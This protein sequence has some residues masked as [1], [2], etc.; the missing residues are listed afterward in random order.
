MRRFVFAIGLIGGLAVCAS[1]RA[2]IG[3]PD[4]LT[5]PFAGA[6]GALGARAG[7]PAWAALVLSPA[8]ARRYRELFAVQEA[9]DWA[10]A[11]ALIAALD[12][13]LLM[14][15]A[16]FQRYMHPTAYRSRFDELAAWLEAYADHPGAK[17]IYRLALRRRPAGAPAPA[18]PEG[19][20]AL[21]GYG[22]VLVVPPS[23]FPS[24]A[25]EEEAG[26]LAREAA[27]SARRD[28]TAAVARGNLGRAESILDEPRARRWLSEAERDSLAARI[29]RMHFAAGNDE[30]AARLAQAAAANLGAAA[31]EAQWTAGLAAWRLGDRETAARHF[32]VL[33]EAG[34]GAGEL[35]AGGAYWAARAYDALGGASRAERM[36]R[37]GARHSYSAYGLLALRQLGG[38]PEFSW[39]PPRADA[40][41]ARLMARGGAARRAAALAEAGR[42]DLAEAELRGLYPDLAREDAA[43]LLLLAERLNLPG[44]ALRVGSQIAAVGGDRFDRALYPLPSWRPEGGFRFDRALVFALIRRESVFET[45][46]ESRAGARGLMQLMPETAAYVIGDSDARAIRAELYAPARNLDLGQ[47]YMAYLARRSHISSNLIYLLAAYNAGP[48]RLRD[49]LERFDVDDPMLFVESMPAPETRRFVRSVLANLWIYRDRLGQPALS[50]AELAAGRW[51]VLPAPGDT[52]AFAQLAAAAP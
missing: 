3:A 48:T 8:D 22:E 9:G 50:L 40:A 51:P 49:W 13:R 38:A 6:H 10:R 7:A 29:A 43:A 52:D 31:P 17:R 19:G 27:A 32:A 44:L 21:A 47:R 18:R 33:A 45:H 34:A 15:H 16:L 28:F 4:A 24:L 23:P 2:E 26:G 37:L 30:A 35:A 36:R 5:A 20:G 42:P 1:A 39:D 11:D 25:P 41:A 46:A 14:G 12:D